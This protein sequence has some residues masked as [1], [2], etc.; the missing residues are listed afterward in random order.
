MLNA[1]I[2]NYIVFLSSYLLLFYLLRRNEFEADMGG[3]ELAKDNTWFIEFLETIDGRKEK[4]YNLLDKLDELFRSY[5]NP[6]NRIKR[7]EKM[8]VIN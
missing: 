4:S 8:K 5:P 6:V 2:F 3:F 1:F 7:L